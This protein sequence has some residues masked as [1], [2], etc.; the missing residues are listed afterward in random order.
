MLNCLELSYH[1]VWK[2]YNI[3]LIGPKK[4]T[5]ASQASILLVS[6]RTLEV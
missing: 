5:E 2:D 1:L 3:C 6:K 4:S